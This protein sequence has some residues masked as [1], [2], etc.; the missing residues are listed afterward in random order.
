MEAAPIDPL[1]LPMLTP[2]FGFSSMTAPEIVAETKEI[3]E[4]NWYFKKKVIKGAEVTPMLMER[5][6]TWYDSDFWRWMLAALSGDL[7]NSKLGIGPVSLKI[8]GLT[9]RRT[10]LLVQFMTRLPIKLP[11]GSD[12]LIQ[13]ALKAAGTALAGGSGLD[14]L[15]G[16][17]QAALLSTVGHFLGPFEFTAR[18]PAKAWLLH[19]CIPT[20]Y[21]VGSDFD[22]SSSA[23]SVQQCE[24]TVEM[25]EE[26]SLV[27]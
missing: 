7:S 6:V 1:A 23:L 25:M 22:A 4:G 11:D 10:M 16:A 26:I 13:T 18:L 20:R 19:G 2:L 5:G 12:I 27:A 9:P 24:M 15:A 21:K 14:V 3:T 17:A 8:G